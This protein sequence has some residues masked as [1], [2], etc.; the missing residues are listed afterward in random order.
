MNNSK[1]LVWNTIDYRITEE[2]LTGSQFKEL[3][4]WML[5]LT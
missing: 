3:S 2:T 1:V 4:S 5:I